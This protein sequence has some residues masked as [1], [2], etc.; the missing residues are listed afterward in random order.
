MVTITK[1]NNTDTPT[2]KAYFEQILNLKKNGEEFP[3]NLDDVW[4]LVYDRKDIAVRSL[5]ESFYEG[6]DFNLRQNAEV[7]SSAKIHNGI[8]VTYKLTLSCFEYLIARKSRPI[9]DVYRQ[10]F[11]DT[12]EKLENYDYLNLDQVLYIIDLIK[13]F[14]FVTHQKAAEA[15]NKDEYIKTVMSQNSKLSITQ[16]AQMFNYYRTKLLD[17]SN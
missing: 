12:I 8:L 15:F 4:A 9:F 7:I 14:K 11:H 3:I 1:L 5:K 16:A 2:V 6:V 13:C 17:K 10:V